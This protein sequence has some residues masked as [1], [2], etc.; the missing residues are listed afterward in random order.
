MLGREEVAV[1][2]GGRRWLCVREAGGGCVLGRE[3]V[4][5]C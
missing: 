5:V 1:C 4:V 3:E 2:Y